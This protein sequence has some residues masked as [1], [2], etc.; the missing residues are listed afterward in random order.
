MKYQETCGSCGH[1]KTAFVHHI[2]KP[3]VNALRQLVDWYERT[4]KPA[5]LQKNLDLTKN[6]YNNFQKLQYFGVVTRTDKGWFPSSTGIAFIYGNTRIP[7]HVAT[8][9]SVV[10]PQN[11][12]AWDETNKKPISVDVT[13]IDHTCYKVRVEYQEEKSRQIEI[14]HSYD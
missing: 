13:E 10:L 6:Q 7:S 8:V 2:N 4:G 9:E 1:V 14:Q 11:H 3:M 5:N 12:P